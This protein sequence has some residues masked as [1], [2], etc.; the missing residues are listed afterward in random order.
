MEHRG[1]FQGSDRPFP[2]RAWAETCLKLRFALLGG[3]PSS[4]LQ[5]CQV[6]FLRAL[7]TVHFSISFCHYEN[8]PAL[9]SSKPRIPSPDR[10]RKKKTCG[11]SAGVARR[12]W[13]CIGHSC[14]CLRTSHVTLMG[15]LTDHSLRSELLTSGHR[16]LGDHTA[17]SFLVQ[18]QIHKPAD[19]RDTYGFDLHT[20]VLCFL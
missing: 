16:I 6:F 11:G 14:G 7:R 13:C 8:D 2:R 9:L 1:T 10:Q 18:M 17:S 15:V 19:S 12:V 3:L 20:F 4:K 5:E